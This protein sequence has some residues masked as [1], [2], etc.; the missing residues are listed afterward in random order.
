MRPAQRRKVPIPAATRKQ[1]IR[2]C[3]A[4]RKNADD[5]QLPRK[6]MLMVASLHERGYECLYYQAGL[7]HLGWYEYE[8]GAMVNR[9]WPSKRYSGL[10]VGGLIG[11]PDGFSWAN[12]HDSVETLAEK[13]RSYSARF[14]GIRLMSGQEW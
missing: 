6:L 7:E 8:I 11:D 13:F 5:S 12:L 3:M 4:K 2:Q 9:Q 1:K 14:L 10:N